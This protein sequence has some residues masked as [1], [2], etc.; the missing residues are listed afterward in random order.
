MDVANHFSPGPCTEWDFHVSFRGLWVCSQPIPGIQ[1]Q[2]SQS[3]ALACPDSNGGGLGKSTASVWRGGRGSTQE[4]GDRRSCH[5]EAASTT[6]LSV[7]G[8]FKAL[9][10]TS[11]SSG[12]AFMAAH[13]APRTQ[14]GTRPQHWAAFTRGHRGWPVSATQSRLH[15]DG[16]KAEPGL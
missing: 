8:G 15:G 16:H 7:G 13:P 9:P 4:G 11:I 3:S 10:S 5:N 14:R 2:P 6:S 1:I 12:K